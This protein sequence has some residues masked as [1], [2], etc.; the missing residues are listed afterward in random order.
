MTPLTI[1]DF[2]DPQVRVAFHA[3]RN[4]GVDVAFSRAD[5]LAF[6][7]E[8]ETRPVRTKRRGVKICGAVQPRDLNQNRPRRNVAFPR[9]NSV[10]APGFSPADQGRRPKITAHRF[11]HNKT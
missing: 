6:Q 8:P 7:I 2:N 9:D 5:A 4:I 1:F 10:C 11:L 3:A